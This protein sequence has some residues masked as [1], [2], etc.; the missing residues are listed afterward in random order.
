MS[1]G[2]YSLYAGSYSYPDLDIDGGSAG[3]A[4]LGYVRGMAFDSAN[5]LYVTSGNS[6]RKITPAG[7]ITTVAGPSPAQIAAQ[8]AT[9]NFNQ[10]G[11]SGDGAAAT[12]AQF[13]NP[14][15]L[16]IDPTGKYLYIADTGNNRI[17]RVTLI[18]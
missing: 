17:R 2:S 8:Q 10:G 3:N 1:N 6:I 14:G 13:L 5:N 11:F 18:Q 12:S 15:G 9:G 16:S 7:V 4:Q